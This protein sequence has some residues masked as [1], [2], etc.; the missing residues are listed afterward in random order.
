LFYRRSN[1]VCDLNEPI[2]QRSASASECV[3]VDSTTG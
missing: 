1:R 3:E 2:A